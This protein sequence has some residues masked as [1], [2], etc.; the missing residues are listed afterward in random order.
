MTRRIIDISDHTYLRE[1]GD[2]W[3][4]LFRLHGAWTLCATFRATEPEA[5]ARAS[6][7]PTFADRREMAEAFPIDR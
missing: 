1:D 6:A 2:G 5:V 7:P 3:W 4:S